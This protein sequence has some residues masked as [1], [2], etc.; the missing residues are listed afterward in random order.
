MFTW[1]QAILG[2]VQALLAADTVSFAAATGIDV[3]LVDEPFTPAPNLPNDGCHDMQSGGLT[4]IN[5]PD[6][7]NVSVDPATGEL[8][9]TIQ[10]PAGGWYWETAN[11]TGLP[12]TIYGVA[13]RKGDDSILWGCARMEDMGLD[14]VALNATGQSVTLQKVQVRIHGS[15]LR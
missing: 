15:F 9:L 7:P 14:T 2:R 5:A 11:A 13:V 12:K 1:M 4:T 10:P 3:W 6:P 8:L